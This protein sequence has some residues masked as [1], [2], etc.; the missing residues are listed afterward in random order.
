[1]IF[2]TAGH[3]RKDAGAVFN[4]RKEADETIKLRN[5]ITAHLQ[6]QGVEV[7]NDAD[8]WDLSQTIAEIKKLSKPNDTVCDLHFNAGSTTA[9]GCEVFVPDDATT[10]ELN[11]AQRLVENIASLLMI[12]NR[13]I[14]RESNSQHK[15]LGMMR[16][17][18]KNV[19]IEVCFISNVND[20]KNYDACFPYLVET[21]AQILGGLTF[22]SSVPNTSPPNNPT[23]RRST[24]HLAGQHPFNQQVNQTSPNGSTTSVFQNEIHTHKTRTTNNE[25]SLYDFIVNTTFSLAEIHRTV[26]AG[27]WYP[28]YHAVFPHGARHLHGGKTGPQ[29]AYLRL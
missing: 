1:M 23:V 16:P 4:G 2:L 29:N 20:M 17:Q 3:H 28:V 24:V 9:T 26:M 8:E 19:L 22:G 18:G 14:K 27:R 15:K 12:K 5:A 11:L 13:G 25:S 6:K 21:I 7:W 10:E